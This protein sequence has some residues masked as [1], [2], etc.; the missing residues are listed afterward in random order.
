MVP[1]LSE[2]PASAL[3]A[4]RRCEKRSMA[5]LLGLEIMHEVRNPLDTLGNRVYLESEVREM[6]TVCSHN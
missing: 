4:L 6:V 5:G 3:D 2:K 1:T